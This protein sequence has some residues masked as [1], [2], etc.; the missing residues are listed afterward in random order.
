MEV[1]AGNVSISREA[2]RPVIQ[3]AYSCGQHYQGPYALQGMMM[4]VKADGGLST[5]F[6]NWGALPIPNI[7][8]S[9]SECGTVFFQVVY[10]ETVE[11]ESRLASKCL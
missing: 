10:R 4:A 5:F 8:F 11:L 7:I 3:R 9:A 6:G 2:S 1:A